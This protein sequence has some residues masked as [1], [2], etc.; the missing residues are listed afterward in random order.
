M[1]LLLRVQAIQA[2]IRRATLHPATVNR[3]R[4]NPANLMVRR[5]NPASPTAPRNSRGSLMAYRN[6]R[7]TVPLLGSPDTFRLQVGNTLK[8]NMG[9]RRAECLQGSLAAINRREGINHHQV[10]PQG[11]I[12]RREVMVLLLQVMV[13]P[14]A[15]GRWLPALAQKRPTELIQCPECHFPT[16]RRWWQGYCRFSSDLSG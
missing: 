2:A 12:H 15:M 7:G 3:R 10:L 9:S 14:P 8:R 16:S 6:S 1:A 5:S 11:A 13:L 4:N